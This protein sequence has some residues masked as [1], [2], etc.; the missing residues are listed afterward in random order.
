MQEFNLDSAPQEFQELRWVLLVAFA[1]SCGGWLVNYVTVIHRSF[2][3]R[4]SGVPLAGLCN[5]LAWELVF[6]LVARPKNLVAATP[7]G[8]WLFFNIFVVVSTIKFGRLPSSG[9]SPLMQRILPAVVFF[10]TLAC[11]SGHMSLVYY[12]GP[13]RALSYGAMIC[14]LTYGMS[15]LELLVQR[16]HTRGA[17]YITW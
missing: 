1:G 16:G 4:T 2:R 8:L 14:Q 10:G 13:T 7:L 3:D 6:G 9:Y 11:V 17:S 15:A 5:N 12:L